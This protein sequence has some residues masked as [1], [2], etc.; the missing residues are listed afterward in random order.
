[1]INKY[2]LAKMN[3]P[4]YLKKFLYNRYGRANIPNEYKEV[5]YIGN[6][7]T[8]YINAGIIPSSNWK[9]E[10]IYK[11][12]VAQGS[13]YVMGS[14]LTTSSNIY[15][16]VGGGQ[17]TQSVSVHNSTC[18]TPS[19]YRR[20]NY[21]YKINSEYNLLGTGTSEIVCLTNNQKFTG[22][23][24]ANINAT[25]NYYI[26]SINTSQIHEGMSLYKLKLWN[27][28][29][30]VRDFIPCYRKSDNV[31]GLYDLVNNTFY[32]NQGTG[33]FIVGPIK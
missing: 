23:Q 6:S 26:F 16:G 11:D 28:N 20:V 13:N 21:I 1:M 29:V 31:A 12:N 4:A 9:Y 18:T 8:Q 19:N 25:A 32:T 15:A 7:G 2:F 3:I 10:I 24:S 30:L 27:N 17:A 33:N 5:E 22:I 14:R